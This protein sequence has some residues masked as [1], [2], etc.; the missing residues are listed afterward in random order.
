[1][2]VVAALVAKKTKNKRDLKGR[3]GGKELTL[4]TSNG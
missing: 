1:M 2:K 4:K 3:V